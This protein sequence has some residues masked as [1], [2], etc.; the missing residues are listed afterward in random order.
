MPYNNPKEWN[1][2]YKTLAQVQNER[3]M[4]RLM[5]GCSTEVR[6]PNLDALVNEIEDREEGLYFDAEW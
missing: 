5:R 1:Q 6:T 2:E 4:R 3:E